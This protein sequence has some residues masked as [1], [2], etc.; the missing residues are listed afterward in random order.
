MSRCIPVPTA[1]PTA[2]AGATFLC[3]DGDYSYSKTSQGACS[4]HGGIKAAV[5]Q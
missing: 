5:G 4:R 1:A 3:G 2:P